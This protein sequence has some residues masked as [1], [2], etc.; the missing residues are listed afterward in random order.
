MTDPATLAPFTQP[1]Y[2][3]GPVHVHADRPDRHRGES[4]MVTATLRA[5]RPEEAGQIAAAVVALSPWHDLGYT[6]ARMETYLATP[7]LLRRV[8]VLE[9]RD[10][11]AG[12]AIVRYPWLRGPYLELL[13]IFPDDQR[14][15]LGAAVLQ[16]LEAETRPHAGNLWCLVSAFNAGAR[17]FY[18]RHDFT[19]VGEI[20]GLIVKHESEILLR[21][22]LW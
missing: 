7:D 22:A 11:V 2:T 17:S 5:L 16:W 18:A 14:V 8:F 10:R 13:A 19:A 15:G 6:V 20:P 3:I 4:I 9:R 1:Q 12:A 21:K